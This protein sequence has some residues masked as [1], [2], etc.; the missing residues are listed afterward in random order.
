LYNGGPQTGLEFLPLPLQI[1]TI[2]VLTLLTLSA[3]PMHI[4]L[5]TDNF[6]P[7]IN[8]PALRAYEHARSWVA[9]GERV[10]VVTTVPNFPTGRPLSPYRNR[11]YQREVVDGIEVVRVWTFLAPNRG[12]ALRSLD[13]LSFACT[14][15]LA[16][17]FERPDA[18]VASSPQLLTG[19]SGWLLGAA[20][21]RPWILEIRDL[22]PDSIVA[23]G[24]MNENV[25]IRSLRWLERRLYANATLIVAVSEGIRDRIAERG[26]P[27]DRLAVVANGVDRDRVA[28]KPRNE[29]L[30][31]ELGLR[32]AFVVGYVGTH[33]LAQG[34]EVVLRAAERMKGGSECFLFVGEGA[35]RDELMALAGRL[36]L[37]N[38]RFVGLVPLT[39]AAEHL[40]LC[41]AVVIP[42]RRTDQIEIT[43]PAKI[44]EAA[45]MEKP[46]I[47]SAE[48]ASARLVE[49]YGAGLVVPPE[50]DE[51]L[52]AAVRRLREEPGLIQ[53]LKEGCR[54]LARDYDRKELA[55]KMLADI[56]AA[57][58]G[59]DKRRS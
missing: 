23:V 52:A 37:A 3:Q 46:M 26:I 28:S 24:L 51:A 20:T 10:T 16:G 17:L 5:L 35:K 1:A 56:R 58:A 18:I 4:L 53:R 39:R 45:A 9:V 57:A 15:F 2:P 47:V 25:F 34:L 41:D 43:I 12:I 13:F 54:A 33:G 38:V 31:D 55:L 44:F 14:S 7:E 59:F 49:R 42:L 30:A 40:A 6:V 32:G 11:L 8:S 48:G 21:G 29:A 36:Q 50:D 27:R 22:W 19:L